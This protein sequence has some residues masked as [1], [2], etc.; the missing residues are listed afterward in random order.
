MRSAEQQYWEK[1]FPQIWSTRQMKDYY[2]P[3]GQLQNA[4]SR[5]VFYRTPLSAS[6]MACELCGFN[7]DNHLDFAR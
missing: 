1:H 3:G 2:I 4:E 6:M 7:C 5:R